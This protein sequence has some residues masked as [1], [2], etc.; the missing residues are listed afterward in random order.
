[1][2][3]STKAHNKNCEH[4]KMDIAIRNPSGFCDHLY[5]PESC[6]VCNAPKSACDCACHTVIGMANLAGHTQK[7]CPCHAEPAVIKLVEDLDKMADKIL[8]EMPDVSSGSFRALQQQGAVEGWWKRAHDFLRLQ[9]VEP[10]AP[11]VKF[12]EDELAQRERVVLD[13]VLGEVEGMKMKHHEFECSG[14]KI[15]ENWCDDED[16]PSESAKLIKAHNQALE[17]IKGAL[18]GDSGTK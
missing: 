10:R 4:C 5:Y 7:N 15:Y 3:D 12:I 2:N 11:I 16:C 14:T 9:G 18:S 6:K 13:W 17:E 1:M 8:D